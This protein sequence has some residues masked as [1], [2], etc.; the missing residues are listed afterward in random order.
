[1]KEVAIIG[2]A[3]HPWGKIKDKSVP[4]LNLEIAQKALKDANLDWKDLQLVVAGEDP[5]TGVDGLLS[6]NR[7]SQ[8]MGWTGIPAV[9]LYAACATG[10]YGLKTA[11]AY[12]TSGLCD[13][14]LCVA[15]SIS[16]E[17]MFG[18]TVAREDDPND[19]DT[20]R[21]RILGLTNPT[22]FALLASLRM[23]NY[24]TTENDLALVKVKN[25]KFGSLNPNARYRKEFSIEEVLNSPMV[26]YPLRL[27]ELCATSDGAAAV[28]L[29]SMNVAKRYTSK[30]VIFAGVGIATPI[31]PDPQSGGLEQGFASDFSNIPPPAENGMGV[32]AAK[33]AYEEA[34]IGPEDLSLAE[35][36]DLSSAFELQWYEDIGLCKPGEA[37][38][39]IREGATA[40][41][42]KIPVNTS[43]GCSSLGEA[44]PAQGLAQVCELVWQ[45]RGEAGARQV[46]DAKVGFDINAG[47]QG[48][49]SAAIVK[50]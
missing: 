11:Q 21:F 40:M 7:L 44:I 4:E 3:M 24:G 10:G 6:G 41:G 28:V 33:N 1:M 15:S 30:P 23:H 29:C 46:E 37:E 36:Y 49:C 47:K 13:V 22:S 26:A 39:L 32:R 9:N 31:Y 43:G 38:G 45:M 8:N 48:N 18:V 20:Q 42:G 14:V 12:I 2:C 50:R 25:S 27:Y 34:G 17:G 16:P 35:V 19:L 5:W